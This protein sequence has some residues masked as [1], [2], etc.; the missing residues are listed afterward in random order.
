MKIKFKPVF[1]KDFSKKKYS[2]NFNSTSIIIEKYQNKL[3]IVL[4]LVKYHHK[5]SQNQRKIQIKLKLKTH[6]NKI[7][8]RSMNLTTQ[9]A[10][11]MY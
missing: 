11:K 3:I 10:K 7:N 1:K 4:I 5:I 9:K 6:S 2:K 8:K